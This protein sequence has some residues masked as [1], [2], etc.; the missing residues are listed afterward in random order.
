MILAALLLT[1][2][3]AFP[4]DM[5][6]LV[7]SADT[8]YYDFWVG[9]W[10]V[11]KDGQIDPA[12]QTFTVARGIHAAALEETWKGARAFRAW[13]KTAGRW[14]HIWIS[15]NGLL[16]VWEGRKVGSDWY[17]FKEFDINGD[18][19]LSRQ[20]VLNRGPGRA[21]RISERS[22]DGGK[23]WVVRFQ[24]DLRRVE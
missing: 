10:V 9:R 19:Y 3:A 7:E 20:A 1:C 12:G 18:R 2:V 24:E 4:Q 21:V 16:Q 22:D 5:A 8:H 13:D 11:E 6:P 23:T 17:M 15:A 14:M